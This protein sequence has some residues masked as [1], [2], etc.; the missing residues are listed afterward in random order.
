LRNLAVIGGVG[1]AGDDEDFS[2]ADVRNFEQ[3]GLA[4]SVG[5]FDFDAIESASDD[6]KLTAELLFGW[7]KGQSLPSARERAFEGSSLGSRLNAFGCRR[8]ALDEY[9]SAQ[10]GAVLKDL[11]LEG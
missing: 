1:L 5:R 10:P 11:I 7:I 3:S 6:G 8:A 9:G 4:G 2:D